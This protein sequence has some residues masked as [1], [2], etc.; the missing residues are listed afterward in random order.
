MDLVLDLETLGRRA[1]CAIIQIGAATFAPSGEGVHELL[2]LHI[3]RG[4]NDRLHQ[5]PQTIAWWAKQS[6]A[7]RTA[8]AQEDIDLRDALKL[9][10]EFYEK[11]KIE[12]IWSHGAAFDV[13]ILEAALALYEIPVPW[14]FRKVRDTRTLFALYAPTWG[15][16][17]VKHVAVND[18]VSCAVAI[19]SSFKQ[20]NKRNGVNNGG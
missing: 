16:N 18:A 20:Y 12:C 13:P 5:D 11:N 2:Q 7:A 6:V 4:S 8:A 17:E 15:K 19:Q 1:G 14:D 9:F 3:T 10:V